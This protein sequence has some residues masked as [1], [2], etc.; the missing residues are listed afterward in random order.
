KLTWRRR[1]LR[2]WRTS[3]GMGSGRLAEALPAHQVRELLAPD[4]HGRESS[5]VGAQ[6]QGALVS[7]VADGNRRVHPAPRGDAQEVAGALVVRLGVERGDARANPM[8]PRGEH[9]V[10]GQA[11]LVEATIAIFHDQ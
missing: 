1:W 4:R 3:A 11:A 8:R 9:D 10:L 2:S 5:P 6:K 7:R